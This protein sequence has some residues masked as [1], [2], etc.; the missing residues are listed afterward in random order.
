MNCAVQPDPLESSTLYQEFQAERYEIM[1]HKW[2]E[3]EKRGYDVGFD[4]ALTDW[5]LKHRAA[6]R[7]ARREMLAGRGCQALAA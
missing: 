1:L 4:Y 7:R 5:I 2:Y 3:S 6:W